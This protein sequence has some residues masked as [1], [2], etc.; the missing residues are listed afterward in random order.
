MDASWQKFERRIS[1]IPE[2]FPFDFAI[3]FARDVF[4]C[5]L[6]LIHFIYFIAKRV[7]DDR[8]ARAR[9]RAHAAVASC[10]GDDPSPSVGEKR[11]RRFIDVDSEDSED[12]N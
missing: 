11:R 8:R 4:F 2:T 6:W 10:D 3:V 7:Y 9:A 5:G 1:T 12:S